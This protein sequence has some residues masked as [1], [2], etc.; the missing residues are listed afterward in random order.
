MEP[1]EFPRPRDWAGRTI[2]D[3]SHSAGNME[4]FRDRPDELAWEEISH[5]LEVNTTFGINQGWYYTCVYY[6]S[7]TMFLELY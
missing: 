3:G 5:I 7:T 1:P 6:K 2:P 4:L